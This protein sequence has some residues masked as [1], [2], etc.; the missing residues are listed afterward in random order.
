[1]NRGVDGHDAD[2]QIRQARAR[3]RDLVA[4]AG[5][6]VGELE[7]RAGLRPGQLRTLLDGSAALKLVHMLSI[8]EAMEMAPGP[9]FRQLHPA[10]RGPAPAMP[11]AV[12][13]E[14]DVVSVY[15]LGVERVARLGS[16]LER[17]EVLLGALLRKGWPPEA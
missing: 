6:S 15:G 17:C 9:F 5:I 12:S 3:L 4:D 2:R 1:M 13:S 7:R 8:L 16:R 14:R 11:V 10:R